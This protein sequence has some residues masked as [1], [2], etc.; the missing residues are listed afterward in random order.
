MGHLDRA[1]RQARVKLGR[2]QGPV[3]RFWATAHKVLRKVRPELQRKPLALVLCSDRGIFP[4]LLLAVAQDRQPDGVMQRLVFAARVR[5]EVAPD[6]W[7]LRP[8]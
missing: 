1:E 8:A 5:R 3:A 7:P 4:V 2:A 6:P